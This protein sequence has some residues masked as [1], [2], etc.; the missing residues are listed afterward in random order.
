MIDYVVDETLQIYAGYGFVE[1]YPADT[2]LSAMPHQPH[3]RG[4]QRNQPAGH[5]WISV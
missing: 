2:R 1:E 3:F 4:H 5:H